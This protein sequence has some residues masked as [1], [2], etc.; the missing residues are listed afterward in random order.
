MRGL[1]LHHA[2]LIAPA[3]LLYFGGCGPTH[4]LHPV[5]VVPTAPI[6]FEDVTERVG[7]RFTH[8]NGADGRLFMPESI[9]NGGAFLDYDGDGW[10]DLFL[11][12]S[13]NWPDRPPA[14]RFCALYHNQK[15]GTFQD[16]TREARLDIPMYGFGC[17]VGDYDNDGR[18]DLLVTCLGPN[19]L[20]RNL[21]SG[22]FRDVT[23]GSGLEKAARWAWHTSAAWVD[24]DADGRL[25]LFVCRYVRWSPQTNYTPRSTGGKPTYSGPEHY[26]GDSCVLYRNVG[27]GRFRDVSNETGIASHQGKALGVLPVDENRDGQ[28]DLAVAN[29]TRPNFLFRSQSAGAFVEAGQEA[30]VA[31]G[32]TGQPRAGMGIDAAD[33][34]NDDGLAIAIGNFSGEGLALFDRGK[35]VYQDVARAAGL[36]PASFSRLTFGLVFAD[37]DRDGWQDLVTCNGHVDPL[38]AEK[39]NMVTF[40]ELPQ[41]FRNQNGSFVDR[42]ALA[43]TPFQTPRVGRGL[44]WGDWNN[45]GRPDLLLCENGGPTRLLENTSPDTHHWLGLRLRGRKGNRNAYGAEVILAAGGVTQRRWIRSGSS[46]LSQSD[47]RALFGL[48]DT[49]RIERLQVRWPSGQATTHTVPT[50][51]RYIEVEE[52]Q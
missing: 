28:P 32:E 39:G 7:V 38:V 35:V 23:P 5:S 15:D 13:S 45:D 50:V 41:L 14:R 6:R 25:D 11:V 17:A 22:R 10:M 40:K 51:D 21:G 30:G 2:L 26:P 44:A 52:P 4:N 9:G 33:I 24:Y 49:T 42:T 37:L 19:R 36:V 3:G 1:K 48:A 27:G 46:Y 47:P 12:N 29:D 18:E 43:G 8:F 31:V 16:V 20:F 34:R